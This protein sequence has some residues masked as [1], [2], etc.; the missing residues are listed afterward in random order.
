MAQRIFPPNCTQIHVITYTNY[1]QFVLFLTAPAQGLVIADGTPNLVL[2]LNQ[3]INCPLIEYAVN[4]STNC[5]MCGT[6]ID[7]TITCTNAQVGSICTVEVESLLCGF[8]VNQTVITF[9]ITNEPSTLSTTDVST[10]KGKS[11]IVIC[12]A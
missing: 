1:I 11:K 7:D 6:V 3:S 8:P 10:Q 4:T 12:M 2:T 5:G 9:N